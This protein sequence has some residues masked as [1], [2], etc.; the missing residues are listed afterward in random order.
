MAARDILTGMGHHVVED[1]EVLLDN[2]RLVFRQL[3]TLPTS[4]SVRALSR[5]ALECEETLRSWSASPPASSHE[6]ESV[7]RRILGLHIG[8]SQLRRTQF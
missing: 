4:T 3:A 8:L 1:I 7:R 2:L 6:R 5:Q